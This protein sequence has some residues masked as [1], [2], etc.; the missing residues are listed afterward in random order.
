MDATPEIWVPPPGPYSTLQD[1][2][3]DLAALSATGTEVV[4]LAYN[5]NWLDIYTVTPDGGNAGD[6]LLVDA[7][8]TSLSVAETW[9]V[10][11]IDDV[12]PTT[13]SVTGS[14]SGAQPDAHEGLYYSNC[15]YV[16]FKI[17]IGTIAYALNDEFTFAT[18]AVDPETQMIADG[19]TEFYREDT[20]NLVEVIYTK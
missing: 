19:Y 12:N 5:P 16:Y 10:T 17:E 9:T 13:W 3:M 2:A 11:C 6:G 1:R 4:Q 7:Q 20:A 14:V 15:P 8:P 18:V